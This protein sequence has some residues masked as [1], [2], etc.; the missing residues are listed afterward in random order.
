MLEDRRPPANPWLPRSANIIFVRGI[1]DL[2]GIFDLG[3]GLWL[4]QLAADD[5]ADVGDRL[6][7]MI[8]ETHQTPH[9]RHRLVN[10][11]VEPIFEQGQSF[12]RALHGYCEDQAVQEST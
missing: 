8:F 3:D 10:K 11:A 12:R 9:A 4:R 5:A 7:D 2:R 6:R 1:I